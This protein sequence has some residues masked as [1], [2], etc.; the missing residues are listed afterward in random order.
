M[1]DGD[2]SLLTATAS[3]SKRPRGLTVSS[4]AVPSPSSKKLMIG[5]HQ[6][7][8]EHRFGN[9]FH[10]PIKTSEAADYY[11]MVKRPLDLKTIRLRLRDG[12]IKDSQEFQRDIYLMYANALVY[13]APQSE[14]YRMTLEVREDAVF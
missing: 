5:L 14:I 4:G 7:I 2:C 10:Q 1:T 11:D 3:S 6:R 8:S 12:T 9:I 13:N